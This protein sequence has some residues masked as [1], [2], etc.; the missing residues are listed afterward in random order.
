MKIIP[1][2]WALEVV[3]GVGRRETTHVSALKDFPAQWALVGILVALGI[4]WAL[5]TIP[6]RRITVHWWRKRDEARELPLGR[7]LLAISPLLFWAAA[8]WVAI[9]KW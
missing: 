1:V 2:Q 6:D 8:A 7:I 5:F 9:R 3:R 4:F